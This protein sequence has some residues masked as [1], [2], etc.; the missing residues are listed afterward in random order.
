MRRLPRVGEHVTVAHLASRM[1]GEV[2]ELDEHRR[3]ILVLTDEGETIT[4]ILSRRTGRFHADGDPFGA[5]L[6]FAPAAGPGDR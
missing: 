4:F 2:K 1:P 6:L 3:R 5:R